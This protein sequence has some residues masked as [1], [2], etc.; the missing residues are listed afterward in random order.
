M[1]SRKT[2]RWSMLAAAVLLAPQAAAGAEKQ[3]PVPR[4][5]ELTK[6]EYAAL[7]KDAPIIENGQRTTRAAI[8]A[9][10][11]GRREQDLE[12]LGLELEAEAARVSVE[13]HRRI[14]QEQAPF[15]ARAFASPEKAARAAPAK[16]LAPANVEAIRR[17][18]EQLSARARTASPAELAAIEKRAAE[19]LR[20][21]RPPR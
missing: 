3:R 18:A 9:R 1:R 15:A 16:E 2:R 13:Q 19:L 6:D 4:L 14:E 12:R 7:P 20:Q 8:E 11:S 21:L 5:E 17:E 10:D